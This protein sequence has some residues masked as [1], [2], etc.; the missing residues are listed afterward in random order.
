MVKNNPELEISPT[1][2]LFLTLSNSAKG[3]ELGGPS[4]TTFNGK[5]ILIHIALV[6]TVQIY[7]VTSG[8]FFSPKL[9]SKSVYFYF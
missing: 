1:T 6:N 2:T 7:S 3:A 5:L 8:N 9:T 4:S